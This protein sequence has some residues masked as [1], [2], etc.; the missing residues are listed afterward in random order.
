MREVALPERLAPICLTAYRR[1]EHTRATLEALLKS[2]LAEHSTVYA[3]LDGPKT[4]GDVSAVAETRAVL[5]A[6]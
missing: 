5:E 2:P 4:E 1:P 3:F 6:T